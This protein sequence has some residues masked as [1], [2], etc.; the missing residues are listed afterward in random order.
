[1]KFYTILLSLFISGCA[2]ISANLIGTKTYEYPPE[3]I[4]LDADHSWYKVHLSC[5][6]ELLTEGEIRDSLGEPDD[7]DDLGSGMVLTYNSD[8]KWIG[9]SIIIYLGVPLP[10]PLYLP[11]GFTSTD[12]YLSEMGELEKVKV[13]SRHEYFSTG[14]FY[15]ATSERP[16]Y[17][18]GYWFGNSPKAVHGWLGES[19]SHPLEKYNYCLQFNAFI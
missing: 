13:T 19:S 10:I 4:G 7:V 14:F 16:D 6:E 18:E 9:L 17:Y 5:K 2:S 12:F 8:N 11:V 15:G 3:Y 1:M